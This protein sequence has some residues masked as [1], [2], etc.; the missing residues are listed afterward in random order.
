MTR[1]TETSIYHRAKHQLQ[2]PLVKRGPAGHRPPIYGS[3]L[4]NTSQKNC[5]PAPHSE[6]LTSAS[7]WC[8]AAI[9]R[10]VWRSLGYMR[11]RLHIVYSCNITTRPSHDTAISVINYCMD[12]FFFF[13]NVRDKNFIFPPMYGHTHTERS[14]A[15]PTGREKF[16]R[17]TDRWEKRELLVSHVDRDSSRLLQSLC[18]HDY[19]QR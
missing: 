16:R 2:R 15:K 17:K 14:V 10:T 3:R 19:W 6:V 13:N 11:S 9:W 12:Y 4:H 8:W 18:R 1:D 5:S 7:S